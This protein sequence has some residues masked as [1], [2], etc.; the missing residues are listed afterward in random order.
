[1]S[2]RSRWRASRSAVARVSVRARASQAVSRGPGRA[3]EGGVEEVVEFD[4][5][6][7]GD[8]VGA[9]EVVD[10]GGREG[11]VVGAGVVGDAAEDALF[12]GGVG[13]ERH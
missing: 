2:G 12:G 9:P 10:E 7:P 8:D 11:G 1:M 3:A 4:L 13:Q 6:G 5:F